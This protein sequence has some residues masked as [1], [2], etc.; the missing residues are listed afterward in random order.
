MHKTIML[1]LLLACGTA[2]ASNWVSVGK[3]HDG[4][5]EWFVDTTSI[6]ID[7]TVRRAWTKTV[8]ASH[9][10]QDPILHSGKWL[11]YMVTR[12][13]IDC[14]DE[15]HDMEAITQY[16]ESGGNDSMPDYRKQLR[17]EPIVP[18]TVQQALMRFICGWKP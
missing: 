1:A 16:Y 12:D 10:M 15:T 11:A 4:N 13:V 18:D 7:N 17:M 6:R 14:R 3:S 5:V 8:F 9:T 2:Q